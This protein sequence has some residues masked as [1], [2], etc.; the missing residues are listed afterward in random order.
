LRRHSLG[1]VDPKLPLYILLVFL[2]VWPASDIFFRILKY[3]WQAWYS[4][5]PFSIAFIAM[6]LLIA[7]LWQAAWVRLTRVGLAIIAAVVLGWIN[8]PKLLERQTNIDVIAQEL[9]RTAAPQDLVIVN[10]WQLGIPFSRQ[11]H[12]RAT[13]VTVP[14]IEDHRF[15]RYDLIKVKM[16]S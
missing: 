7:M 4:L 13:W 16:M 8:W 15:H 3:N 2:M 12:G 9:N 10:P 5:A 1:E 11:Y 14:K 6:D